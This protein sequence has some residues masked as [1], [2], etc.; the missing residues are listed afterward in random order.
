MK[1]IDKIKVYGYIRVSTLTQAEKGYGLKAQE[2]A[3]IKYCKE[4]NLEL[5]N[6]FKDKGI[7]GA[8]TTQDEAG[9]DREGLNDLLSSLN[10]DINRI[11]VLNTSRLWRSDTVKVLIHRELK[12]TN[13]DVISIEQPTY[14]I[15]FK[16]PNDFLI[17]GMMELLDQYDRMS[18]A[19]KLARGRKTKAKGGDKGCGNAP[20][21][22][23]WDNAKIIIDYNK[24]QI[25]K[26]I[27]SLAVK[28]L[29]SQ[30]IADTINTKGYTTDRGN[31]FSK[32]AVHLILTNDFYTGVI[33]HGNIKKDGNHEA[34]INKVT[35]GKVQAALKKRRKV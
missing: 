7:S 34:L 24:S 27:F 25:V 16:D 28:G 17:N 18:I 33:T 8:K 26:E 5:I 6:I 35:F 4:N 29:S 30:K 31:K 1:I 3:I 20:I 19:L 2:E 22:Y 13:S 9:V 14:S 12:K 32:Q 21:G 23:K 10:K 11:V 15:Y